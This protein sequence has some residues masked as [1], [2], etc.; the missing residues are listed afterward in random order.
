MAPGEASLSLPSTA[1]LT[2]PGAVH[3][4]LSPL[5]STDPTCPER[6]ARPAASLL[7]NKSPTA[8]GSSSGPEELGVLPEEET[9]GD[10]EDREKEI[11]IERIQSIKEEKQVSS[12]PFPPSS[13][14]SSP[15][16]LVPPLC[17]GDLDVREADRPS[18]VPRPGPISW[19][20][21]VLKHS[22]GLCLNPMLD[23]REPWRPTGKGRATGNVQILS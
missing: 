4:T 17:I 7:Q 6:P 3:T 12:V 23:H 5:T 2:S 11:L 18:S 8:R 1:E 16:P 22:L 19:S 15:H 10:D 14:P 21:V 20:A 13:A 9:A